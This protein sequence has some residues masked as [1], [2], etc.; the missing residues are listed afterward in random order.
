MTQF[1]FSGFV[2][3][4]VCVAVP[5][6]PCLVCISSYTFRPGVFYSEALS[7]HTQHLLLRKQTCVPPAINPNVE[8]QSPYNFSEFCLCFSTLLVYVN[9]L[10]PPPVEPCHEFCFSCYVERFIT[11]PKTAWVFPSI[12]FF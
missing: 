4:T 9:F 1:L 12:Y 6:A 2:C 3:S 10:F 8:D 11:K 7:Q 5:Q